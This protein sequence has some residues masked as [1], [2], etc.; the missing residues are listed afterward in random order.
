VRTFKKELF[1]SINMTT[2][3][4]LCT[5]LSEEEVYR[6]AEEIGF[7]INATVGASKLLAPQHSLIETLRLEI[8][9]PVYYRDVEGT[10]AEIEFNDFSDSFPNHP[11]AVQVLRDMYQSIPDLRYRERYGFVD[12]LSEL[13]PL[14]HLFNHISI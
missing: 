10:N 12:D 11:D 13:L 9:Q 4:K 14:S 2:G 8:H 3:L 7:D 6:I 1:K 5:T